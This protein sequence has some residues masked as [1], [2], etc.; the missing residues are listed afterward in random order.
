MQVIPRQWEFDLPNSNLTST[1]LT[2]AQAYSAIGYSV[3]PLLGDLDPTR[4]KVPGISWSRFQQAHASLYEHNQ[5][6]SESQ[7][8]GIGIVTGHISKLVV[9]DFDS[10]DVFAEFRIRYLDL[11]DTHTVRSAGRQLPHLYFELPDHLHI[12]SMKGQGIDVLSNGR[13][14][15]APP[16]SINGQEYKIIRGGMPKQL[17]ERDIRCIQ[18]FLSANKPYN[19]ETTPQSKDA[20]ALRLTTTPVRIT[21]PSENDLHRLYGHLCQQ[22]SRNEAL[23]RTSLYARN[24]GWSI[25]ETQQ[26][27]VQIHSKQKGS[28]AQESQRQRQRE[29]LA[30]IRSAFSRSAR[31][32]TKPALSQGRGYLPNSVRE[33]LLQRKMTYLVRTLEGLAASGIREGQKFSTQQVEKLLKGLVG[34][35]SIHKALK[36]MVNDQPIFERVFPVNPFQTAKAVARATPQLNNKKCSLLPKKNQEKPQGGRPEHYYKMPSINDLCLSLKVDLSASDPLERTDL[37]SAHKTRMAI[38]RE[39]IKRRP[40][41]YTRRWLASRLGVTKPTINRYNRLIPI[42]SRPVYTETIIS[43]SNIERLPFDEPLQGAFLQTIQGK[44]YPALRIIASMLLTKGTYIGL[45][46]QGGNYY[47]YGDTKPLQTFAKELEAKQTS[48]TF[49]QQ[50]MPILLPECT[51]RA[52]FKP[53]NLIDKQTFVANLQY[54]KFRRR[55]KNVEQELLAQYI[56]ATLNSIQKKQLSLASA[57]RIASVETEATIQAAL[58]LVC[59]RTRANNSAGLLITILRSK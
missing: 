11:I 31:V 9:L 43:W 46:E 40:G 38:H 6:F 18:A 2:A 1:L 23:F 12:E 7:F 54:Q 8:A 16:T 55:L 58:K 57:R 30:T 42:H 17:T 24:T 53:S 33:A 34:R 35:D 29:A 28:H 41:Q 15:V 44:K 45:K 37:S 20:Q 26:S 52:H 21:R 14:V 13:Y 10:E 36:S 39:L 56:Y 32:M 3:I 48:K 22:G 51:E 50:P 59:L 19:H 47:W 4:P 25:E 5:W 49:R 27:L